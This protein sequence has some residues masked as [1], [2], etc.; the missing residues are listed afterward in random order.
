MAVLKKIL[1]AFIGLGWFLIAPVVHAFE[2]TALVYHDVVPD[3]GKEPYSLSRSQFVAQMD[4]LQQHGFHPVSLD[5]LSKAS[6]GEGT[7]PPKS[8]L[9]TFDDALRSYAEFV[10]P[11]LSI[12][13]Y[14]SV[15]SVVGAWADGSHVPKEYRNRLMS[16]KDIQK[17]S[18]N[19]MVEIIS[20]SHDLHDGIA[21]NPQGNEAAATITRR[22]EKEKKQYESETS[23]RKRIHDDLHRSVSE[24]REHLGYAPIAIAWPY[25]YYDQVLLEEKTNA[26]IY[27][28]LTLENGVSHSDQFPRIKRT[29]VRN[30]DTLTGFIEDFNFQYRSKPQRVVEFSLNDFSNKSLKAQEK[31]LSQL[32]DRLQQLHANTVIISPFTENQKAAFF[33]NNQMPVTTD[34]LNRVLHQILTRLRV[35]NLYLRLPVEPKVANPEEL[36]RDLAR[37]NWFTGVVLERPTSINQESRLRE[38]LNYF[39]PGMKFGTEETD[40]RPANYDFRILRIYSETPNAAE[41]EKAKS[42]K[43]SD[44]VLFSRSA[45]TDDRALANSL[46]NLSQSGVNNYGFTLYD[47]AGSSSNFPL[48]VNEM[49]KA[50]AVSGVR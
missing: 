11:I 27:F 12:Y 8:V 38:L 48:L 19:K 1:I 36:Y 3:P 23:F 30:T 31:L 46:Q 39:H 42:V 17:L 32:L 50:T 33:Y 29:I 16:W 47:F 18:S 45:A 5:Q 44:L 37:L 22:Y 43:D 2:L 10:V 14:P 25:G 34:Y 24:F 40:E 35:Q 49:S 20:H 21:S 6:R 15:V 41:L 4:Y 28:H 26:G 7:L 9:L 13:G